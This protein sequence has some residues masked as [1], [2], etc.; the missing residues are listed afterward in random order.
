MNGGD[1]VPL[2]IETEGET[3]RGSEN[4][5]QPQIDIPYPQMPLC[6]CLV[7]KQRGEPREV[8]LRQP[9]SVVAHLNDQLPF[10]FKYIEADAASARRRDAMLHCIFYERLHDQPGDRHIRYPRRHK[11]VCL[12]FYNIHTDIQKSVS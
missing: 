1:C 8:V 4:Q 2:G 3:G 10:S 12:L 7:Q 6:V 5:P 9:F 11:I